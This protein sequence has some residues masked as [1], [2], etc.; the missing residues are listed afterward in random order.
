MSSSRRCRAIAF[1]ARRPRAR[2]RAV[3]IRQAG[4]LP[5]RLRVAQKVVVR[6][7]RELCGAGAAVLV[8]CVAF[9]MRSDP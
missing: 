8:A 3:V 2:E 9:P 5:A 1:V 6:I 7:E 4:L